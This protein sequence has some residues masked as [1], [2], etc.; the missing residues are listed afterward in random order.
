MYTYTKSRRNDRNGFSTPYSATS[1]T[2]FRRG[3]IISFFDRCRTFRFFRSV[4]DSSNSSGRHNFSRG[5]AFWRRSQI[6]RLWGDSLSRWIFPSTNSINACLF[7]GSAASKPRLVDARR[8]FATIF[9]IATLAFSA[10]SSFSS[11]AFGPVNII[12]IVFASPLK[13]R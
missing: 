7:F 5:N 3:I 9:T 13:K 4:S 11:C 6:W 2:F 8:T 12:R 10:S 1:G